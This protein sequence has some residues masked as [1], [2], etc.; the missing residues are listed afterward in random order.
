MCPPSA[1]SGSSRPP[2]SIN[3]PRPP[4]SPKLDL[5]LSDLSP[6]SAP[7][8]PP[9][10]SDL[11]LMPIRCDVEDVRSRLAKS[12]PL[13]ESVPG[14]IGAFCASMEKVSMMKVRGADMIAILTR[15]DEGA[16]IGRTYL[17]LDTHPA[18]LYDKDPFFMNVTL[19]K[20][21]SQLLVP[22]RADARIEELPRGGCIN[23]GSP[24]SGSEGAS[25]QMFLVSIEPRELAML[26]AEAG[27]ETAIP[28]GRSSPPSS[29]LL[30]IPPIKKKIDPPVTI[31]RER[32]ARTEPVSGK[33]EGFDPSSF[34]A[35]VK[36]AI[37]V[38]GSK[39]RPEAPYYL[40]IAGEGEDAYR[41]YVDDL[42]DDVRGLSDPIV[43]R[44]QGHRGPRTCMLCKE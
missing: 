21:R 30:S 13:I 38:T 26:K 23:L 4:K 29:S 2:P 15:P 19:T 25:R 39:D 42:P 17:L 8:L 35:S 3:L 20:V 7:A 11:S 6:K 12:H 41:L 31:V 5:D 24:G 40:L 32:I 1:G 43:L 33:A 16:G 22:E 34:S 14:S 10:L 44:Y 27:K 28:K 37:Y 9:S 36:W 18:T